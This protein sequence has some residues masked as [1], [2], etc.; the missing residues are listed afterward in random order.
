MDAASIVVE[1]LI[2]KILDGKNNVVDLISGHRAASQV[3]L[4]FEYK[5]SK[6]F[7][8]YLGQF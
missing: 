7:S 3:S 8:S 5:K 1:M 4:V 2:L 6:P